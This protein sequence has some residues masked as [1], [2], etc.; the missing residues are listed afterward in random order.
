MLEFQIFD[1][2]RV[3]D[4]VTA[5]GGTA[6]GDVRI[7][8]VTTL[9]GAGV[10]VTGVVTATSFNIGSNQVVSSARQLQNIASLDA[11]TTATIESCS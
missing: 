1:D 7:A 4:A 3:A 10:N 8:G 2:F 5:D 11:T 6:F 9:T